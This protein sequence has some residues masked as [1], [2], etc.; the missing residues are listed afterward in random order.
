MVYKLEEQTVKFNLLQTLQTRGAAGLEYFSIA[1]KH[2]LA[3]ANHYDGTYLLDSTVYQWNGQQFDVF[4]NIPTKGAK[5]FTFCT[6]NSENYLTVANYYDGSTY[7]IKSVIYKWSSGRFSK[8]QEIP[9]DGARGCAAFAINND[10][11]IAF[12]YRYN[13]KQKYAVHSTVFKWSGGHFV[14]LQ[15]LQTYGALGVTSVNVNGD[16]FLAFAK[17]TLEVNT[18]PTRL[19]TNGMAT[20]LFCSSP[21][22]LVEPKPRIPL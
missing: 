3:V 2:F 20:S 8:F 1:D 10:T 16:T 6:I 15:S 5:G 4:Q 19:F 11:L 17:F 18:T 9:T 13:S 7:S 12:A 14:K 21:F 22:L